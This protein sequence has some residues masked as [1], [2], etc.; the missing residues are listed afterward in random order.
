MSPKV[1]KKATKHQL[2]LRLALAGVSGGGKTYTALLL[3]K[4]LAPGGRIAVI[5]TE[6]ES[7]KLYADEF[8][9]DWAGL[10]SYHPQEYIDAIHAAEAGGYDVIIVDSL[11][12]A[13]AGKDGLLD[14]VNKA[15]ARS[16]GTFKAWG[17]AGEV[18]NQLIDT[19]TRCKAHMICTMRSKM[20]HILE[21][22]EKGKK[23][24]RK[25]G[26]KVIQRDDVEY[27]FTVWADMDK[28]NRM[29]VQ[30]SR[31]R[32]L[33]GKVIQRPGKDVAD[34]LLAWLN[35]GAPEE[36][37]EDPILGL[38]RALDACQTGDDLRKLQK[39]AADVGP[40]G[41]AAWNTRKAVMVEEAKRKLAAPTEPAAEGVAK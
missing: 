36:P 31:C 41:I 9:F 25:V 33:S 1:F 39:V 15:A 40:L 12:H 6:R 17:P 5:D 8:E 20:E 14:E 10:D 13:W 3:A 16:G 7:A 4:H 28:D 23:T 19:I 22:D 11:S 21:E 29:I 34:T 37:K 38:Q 32:A 2:K 26:M 18:Q 30:K 24:V 27:E 35:A